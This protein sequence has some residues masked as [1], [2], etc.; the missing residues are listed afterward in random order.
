M[1]HENLRVGDGPSTS[2]PSPGGSPHIKPTRPL[3]RHD[4]VHL[5]HRCVSP[6]GGEW[7]TVGPPATNK[8]PNA[9][10]KACD[11]SG[12]IPNSPAAKRTGRVQHQGIVLNRIVRLSPWEDDERFATKHT[13]DERRECLGVD[14]ISGPNPTQDHHP[15]GQQGERHFTARVE[16]SS[17]NARS[18]SMTTGS[19]VGPRRH[20]PVA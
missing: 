3:R 1:G 14:L 16:T 19:G 7:H 17:T 12:S 10:A 11:A 15:E 13:N 8:W 4:R 18:R 9:S 2:H 20:Q 5:A 6:P